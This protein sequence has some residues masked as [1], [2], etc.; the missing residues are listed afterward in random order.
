MPSEYDVLIPI[1]FYRRLVPTSRWFPLRFHVLHALLRI[2]A[3]TGNYVPLAPF[4]LEILES[5]EF[6]RANPKNASLK[7][8]DLEYVIKAPASYP[9][10]KIYQ[11]T[12]AEELV[13]LLGDFHAVMSTNIAFPEM[14]IPVVFMLKRYL[15]KGGASGKVN[16]Q[17]KTLVEKIEVTRQ[18]VEKKRRGVTFAPNDRADVEAFL[19]GVPIT[20]TPIGSWM[21]L[22]KKVRDQKRKEIEMVRFGAVRYWLEPVIT[23]SFCDLQAQREENKRAPVASDS[24][25]EDEDEEDEDEEM[26]DDE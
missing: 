3:R 9:K 11:E 4:L 5:V 16:N 19:E 24:E 21:R 6:K 25:E 17:L 14:T 10:T 20:E 15:K 1:A 7:P 18:W 26:E 22:Q 2:T 23:I 13:Y 12:L 8:L